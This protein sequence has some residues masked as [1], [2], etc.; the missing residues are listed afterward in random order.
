MTDRVFPWVVAFFAVVGMLHAVGGI[1]DAVTPGER[2]SLEAKAEDAAKWQ[3]S[4]DLYYATKEKHA[5][6]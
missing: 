4:I 5:N 2:V 3:R 1:V 6:K